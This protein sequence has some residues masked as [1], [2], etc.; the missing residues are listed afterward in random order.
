MMVQYHKPKNIFVG[1][2]FDHQATN[3]GL[4]SIEK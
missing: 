1:M 3:V 2:L 4:I